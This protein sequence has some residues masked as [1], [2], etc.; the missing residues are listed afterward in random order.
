MVFFTPVMIIRYTI[1]KYAVWS[2]DIYPE[3]RIFE[4]KL[5]NRVKR[6]VAS[7]IREEDQ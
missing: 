5:L 1:E 3:S 2:A 4:S 6:K 7:L